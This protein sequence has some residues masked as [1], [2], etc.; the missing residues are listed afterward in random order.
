MDLPIL[1]QFH[2][3]TNTKLPHKFLGQYSKFHEVDLAVISQFQY[4]H[5][6]TTYESFSDQYIVFSKTEEMKECERS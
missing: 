2:F 4:K 6:A 3:N 1:S 5:E